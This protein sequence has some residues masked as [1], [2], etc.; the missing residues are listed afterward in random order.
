[1]SGALFS[2][3]QF[4]DRVSFG[5]VT[6][7][8]QGIGVATITEGFSDVDGVLGCVFISVALNYFGH[9]SHFRLGPT[10]LTL[11]TLTPDRTSSI[12]TGRL[13]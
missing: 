4:F 10:V 11:G 9:D 8:K 6:I 13:G 3:P 7:D 12:L 5:G 1:M 2:G